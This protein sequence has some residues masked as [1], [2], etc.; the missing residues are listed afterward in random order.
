MMPDMM[1][2]RRRLPPCCSK[3]KPHTSTASDLMSDYERGLAQFR[4]MVGAERIDAL[5]ERFRAVCPDFEKEV[6][7]VVGGRIWTR[8]GIDLK[9]R[10]LCSICV[11]AALGRTNAL[12]LNFDMALNNGANLEEIFEALFQ[13]AVYA[14]FPAMW[15]ALVMLEEVLAERDAPR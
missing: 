9:T 11:L 7:S 4:D 8:G 12:A 3:A 2:G 15:D 1:P 6:V 5:V 13:V 10:S 14:G